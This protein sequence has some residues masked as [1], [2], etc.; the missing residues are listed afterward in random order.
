[1]GGLGL[2]GQRG[3]GVERGRWRGGRG[4]GE[5]DGWRGG[6]RCCVVECG[7]VEMVRCGLL[8]GGGAGLLCGGG[9]SGGLFVGWT[10]SQFGVGCAV[11]FESNVLVRICSNTRE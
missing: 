11:F 5:R 1:M 7:S 2:M 6:W 10:A 9:G 4:R 8:L 3:R